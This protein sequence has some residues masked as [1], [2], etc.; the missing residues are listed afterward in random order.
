MNTYSTQKNSLCAA[1]L[2]AMALA[3]L[4]SC[5][6][7]D[8]GYTAQQI[9]YESNFKK[10]FGDIP[11]DQSWD[12][13]SYANWQDLSKNNNG[14]NDTRAL[15]APTNQLTSAHFSKGTDHSYTVDNRLLKWMRERLVEGHDNRYLGS[16]F[17]LEVPENDFMIIPI[18]QGNSA[19]TSKL[20]MKVNNYAI[21]EIWQKSA[22]MRA[23]D[24][25]TDDY[26]N[27][28]YYEGW[29]NYN[30][31]E[32][33][34]NYDRHAASTIKAVSVQTTPY[35][36]HGET[37]RQG[38]SDGNYYMYLSLLNIDKMLNSNGTRWDSNNEW[39]TL[40]D[41]LTSIHPD[42]YMRALEVDKSISNDVI[43]GLPE[44]SGHKATQLLIVGCE[45]A[46]GKGSD[47]DVND[48]VFLIAGY[49][50][51]PN[52]I[53]TT[54]VIE[55]RYMCEDLGGT[56]DFDFNDI[57]VDVKQSRT[58]GIN[59]TPTM[60]REAADNNDWSNFF[61]PSAHSGAA[62]SVEITGLNYSDYVQSQSAKI[63]HVCGTLPLQVQ[64]G[65]YLF[66]W[67][68]DPT[69]QQKT[70]T[71][72][73]AAGWAYSDG[74]WKADSKNQKSTTRAAEFEVKENGWN[75]NE[76][77]IIDG[78]RPEDN[79]ITIYVQWP[80][81]YKTD[82]GHNLESPNKDNLGEYDEKDNAS[83]PYL[84]N[85]LQDFKDFTISG[86]KQVTF[87]KDGAVPYII[88]VDPSVH[89]ML[90]LETIDMEW[91]RS[92][93]HRE[94]N[95]ENEGGVGSGAYYE[96]PNDDKP[97]AV[98]WQGSYTGEKWNH[99]LQLPINEA[100]HNG[101]VEALEEGFNTLNIYFDKKYIDRIKPEEDK[102][103]F[104]V[105]KSS[106]W[107]R[108]HTDDALEYLV[109]KDDPVDLDG[110]GTPD[111]YRVKVL[112]T[113][114]QISA[115]KVNGLIFQIR[116]ANVCYRKVSL[117]KESGFDV[118]L[119][120]PTYGKIT[121]DRRGRSWLENEHDK[122]KVPFDHASFINPITLTFTGTSEW[123][124]YE[125][126]DG[127]KE[128][129]RE[130]SSDANLSVILGKNPHLKLV[131]ES[132][133]DIVLYKNSPEYTFEVESEN[134]T[135][136][137]N[138]EVESAIAEVE[139]G[140]SNV[141]KVTPKTPGNFTFKAYQ[142]AKETEGV[143]YSTSDDLPISVHVY[144]NGLPRTLWEGRAESESWSNNNQ[145]EI[146][147]NAIN[148]TDTYMNR[149]LRVYVEKLVG[150]D[151]QDIQLQINSKNTLPKAANSYGNFPKENRK[152]DSELSKFYYEIPL[153]EDF[154][155][156]IK[157]NQTLGLKGKN[158]RI[159]K[160]EFAKQ[161]YVSLDLLA[162]NFD[163][164]TYDKD[165]HTI[166]FTQA[167]KTRT[168]SLNN[169]DYS[170]YSK[171]V[172]DIANVSTTEA[173]QFTVAYNDGTYGSE[174]VNQAGKVE[175]V[176]ENKPIS[177]LWIQT[178]GAVSVKLNSIYFSVD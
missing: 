153:D 147:V 104:T 91:L 80:D 62:P 177:Q 31:Y 69:N 171:V 94:K 4:P 107:S 46:N 34:P 163:G 111:T 142:L 141:I 160:V 10:A 152:W 79:N 119:T 137:K 2:G 50:N 144:D 60:P 49:P 112:L 67:I 167:W 35:T 95:H 64:V 150:G 123:G 70:R 27:L 36:F 24:Q 5:Q 40:N 178:G 106:G 98:V 57:V 29:K 125:W 83:N 162:G 28:G 65:N 16:N 114:D 42:G 76:E 115:L 54:E 103:E 92:V 120:A 14:N 126:S 37:I 39:T 9:Q 75:P 157:E 58:Y 127:S 1:A 89:W 63:A 17:L 145:Y 81:N 72:L 173:V 129:T 102:P 59:C 133:A 164:S 124:L 88:A 172:L 176:L 169:G 174:Q 143:K 128:N 51:V 117:T 108:L 155:N 99:A 151:D 68:T 165:N 6:D 109:T 38:I 84:D 19:I 110:D 175:I 77:K 56:F 105:G 140:W 32:A 55:K 159:T 82:P 113:E 66:P 73:C 45:D 132:N 48:I 61:N 3:L 78:W 74:S 148:P 44:I 139:S 158:I 93:D 26:I 87:P 118:R 121:A 33:G 166:N 161:M 12:L 20:E 101:I 97:E 86:L 71:E 154:F 100:A 43:N 131:D 90:E 8:F 96:Y 135:E 25:D 149:M 21:T 136:V 18:F 11:V 116:A 30:T 15:L 47:H 156:A 122:E 168:I 52:L 22:G 23:K 7:E 53:P 13:S 85:N 146:K 130:V 134:H 41:R 138:K 170:E